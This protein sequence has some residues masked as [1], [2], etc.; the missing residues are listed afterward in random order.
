MDLLGLDLS[1]L[2][3][4]QEDRVPIPLILG[5]LAKSPGIERRKDETRKPKNA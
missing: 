5:S 2:I 4:D 1:C 3:W